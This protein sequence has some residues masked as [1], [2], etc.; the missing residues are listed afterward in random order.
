MTQ[1]T[2]QNSRASITRRKFC[3]VKFEDSNGLLARPV[4]VGAGSRAVLAERQIGLPD[5]DRNGENLAMAALPVAELAAELPVV[6]GAALVELERHE[7]FRQ[8]VLEH[9]RRDRTVP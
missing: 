8:H 1:S 6:E 5:F 9:D 3:N 2:L 7:A 4:T